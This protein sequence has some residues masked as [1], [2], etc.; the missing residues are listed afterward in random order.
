MDQREGTND[1]PVKEILPSAGQ[2][3]H[4]RQ[5]RMIWPIE[6]PLTLA[7]PLSVSSLGFLFSG[8]AVVVGCSVCVLVNNDWPLIT[9]ITLCCAAVLLQQL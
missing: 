4:A 8:L 5:L 2:V 3:W 7:W 9:I 6:A 1:G